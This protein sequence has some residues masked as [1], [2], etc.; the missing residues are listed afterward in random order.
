MKLFN[1][2]KAYS[3]EV[4]EWLE[5]NIPDLTKYQKQRIREDEIIRFAP[6]EF[7]KK[8]KKIDNI[9]IRLS[10][11]FVPIV[12]LILVLGLPFNFILTGSWGYEEIKWVSTWLRS[13]GF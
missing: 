11:I 2:E 4:N 7:Y 13:C 10:I 6:F 1:L 5:E 8:G 9:W 12:W 3:Y